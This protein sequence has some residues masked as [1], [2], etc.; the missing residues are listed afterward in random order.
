MRT[1]PECGIPGLWFTPSLTDEGLG[2]HSCNCGFEEEAPA[3]E[4]SAI[5]ASLTAA[6][7]TLTQSDD[8]PPIRQLI[9]AGAEQTR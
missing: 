5:V 4:I 2:L 6:A 3:P 1:C 9:Q 7:S 8:T